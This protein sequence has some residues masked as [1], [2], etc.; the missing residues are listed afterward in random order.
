[1]KLPFSNFNWVSKPDL[2]TLEKSLKYSCLKQREI[3]GDVDLSDIFPEDLGYYIELDLEYPRYLN[4]NSSIQ[5]RKSRKRG[6]KTPV[7]VK[8][9]VV[10]K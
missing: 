9:T 3:L 10:T 4:K 2:E 6:Y 7:L 1:M 8:G 5:F